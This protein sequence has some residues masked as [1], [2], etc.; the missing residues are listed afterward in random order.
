MVLEVETLFLKVCVLSS[1]LLITQMPFT[2]VYA[3]LEG[4]ELQHVSSRTLKAPGTGWGCPFYP[5][6]A[7]QVL[8]SAIHS[9]SCTK[10]PE[11]PHE[12]ANERIVHAGNSPNR[13]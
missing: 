11:G 12:K 1:G 13:V 4:K 3:G 7:S 8:C 10:A 5:G 6:G 9:Y 2:N